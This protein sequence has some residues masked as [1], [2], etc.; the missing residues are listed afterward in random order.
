MF[1]GQQPQQPQIEHGVGSGIIISP[2]G[3]IVTNDHVVDGATNIKVTLHD[4]RML[5]AKVIGVDKLTDLAVIK[6]DANDL[7]TRG[8]GRLDQAEAGPDGAGVRQPVRLLPVLGDARHCE[9]GEPAESL[10]DD[11]RKPGKFIQTDAAINP[12]NS[13]GP[14]VN[15]HGELVGINTFIISNSGCVCG[16]WI[17]D[18]VADG[19]S[20]G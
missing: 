5:N 13:G 6:I 9:R 8:L 20:H 16:C 18:S 10:S 4:R 17:C 1:R 2:D 19:A 11:A 14:L 3:Y 12:G 7:P 15:A